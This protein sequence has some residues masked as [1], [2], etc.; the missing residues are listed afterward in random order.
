MGYLSPNSLVHCKLRASEYAKIQSCTFFDFGVQQM[1]KILIVKWTKAHGER[2][3]L[4][5]TQVKQDLLTAVY[6]HFNKV[7]VISYKSRTHLS[8]FITI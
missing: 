7:Y 4:S 1:L 8:D 5:I 2:Y 3:V 6:D